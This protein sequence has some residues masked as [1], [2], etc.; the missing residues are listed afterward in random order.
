MERGPVALF[1]A[2]LAVGLGPALWLGAHF[3]RFDAVPSRAPVSV[4]QTHA[5][6]AQLI[7]GS[8][9]GDNETGDGNNT[10]VRSTPR[11]YTVPLNSGRSASPSTSA[12]AATSAAASSGPTSSSTPSASPSQSSDPTGG[13]GAGSGGGNGSGEHSQPPSPP[14]A[15]SG[16]GS[17]GGGS[18]GGGS[19]GGDGGTGTGGTG[20]GSSDAAAVGQA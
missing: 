1:G 11:A 17:G 10:P 18:G 12:A 13:T 14:T 9:A 6:T 7:G 5:D 15:S 20:N 16:D 19:G 4:D 3:G 8:G 2:I